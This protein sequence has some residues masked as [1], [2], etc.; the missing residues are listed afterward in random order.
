VSAQTYD[1]SLWTEDEVMTVM[2]ALL[3][4]N[5]GSM[6]EEDLLA[7]MDVALSYLTAQR[8]GAAMWELVKDGKLNLSVCDG[9]VYLRAREQG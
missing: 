5:G 4:G 9:E 3:L 8:V 2:Q 6:S 1:K 7:D